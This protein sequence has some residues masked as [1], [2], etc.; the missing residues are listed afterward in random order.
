LASASGSKSL[1]FI[2]CAE[3]PVG[4][5]FAGFVARSPKL[6]HLVISNESVNDEF[7][8]RLSGHPSL[9]TLRLVGTA[10]TDQCIPDPVRWKSLTAVTLPRE[11][12]L[13]AS[14]TQLKKAHPALKIDVE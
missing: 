14:I 2:E 5:E 13:Q 3:S 4:S 10:V 7:V 11:K 6:A 9:T 8:A 12:V 1:E